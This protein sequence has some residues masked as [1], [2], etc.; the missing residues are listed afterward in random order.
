MIP[1]SSQVTG[2]HDGSIGKNRL[3]CVLDGEIG[4]ICR[5]GYE[6]IS[7]RIRSEGL[8]RGLARAPSEAMLNFRNT[9]PASDCSA[10]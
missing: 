9:P 10:G 3:R 5:A 7:A 2:A 1:G 8:N 6:D 4:R